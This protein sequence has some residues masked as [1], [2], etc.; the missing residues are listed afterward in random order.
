MTSHAITAHK[1]LLSHPTILKNLNNLLIYSCFVHTN[2]NSLVKNKIIQIFK[3]EISEKKQQRKLNF[4]E[5][6]KFKNRK[7]NI[8]GVFC[9]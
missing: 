7:V 8:F 3:F 5:H 9:N 1:V 2:F 4:L 6:L